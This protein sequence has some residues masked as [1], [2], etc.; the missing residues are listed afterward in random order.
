MSLSVTI[1]GAARNDG[2][3]CAVGCTYH[4]DVYVRNSFALMRSEH[5]HVPIRNV[6]LERF[7]PSKMPLMQFTMD[8]SHSDW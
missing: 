7:A 4:D 3:L 5:L 8:K 2:P 6:T 1:N